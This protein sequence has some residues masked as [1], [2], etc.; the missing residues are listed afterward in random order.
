MYG[1]MSLPNIEFHPYNCVRVRAS[2]HMP[3]KNNDFTFVVDLPT[4]NLREN[5]NVN[6][7]W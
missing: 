6:I 2:G 5:Y 3:Q 7:P 1:C 4:W